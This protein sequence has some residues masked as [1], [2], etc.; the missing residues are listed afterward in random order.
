MAIWEA[1]SNGDE[2]H[3]RL[4]TDYGDPV[5]INEWFYGSAG[6]WY[7]CANTEW[8]CRE[9]LIERLDGLVRKYER[10]IAVEKMRLV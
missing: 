8:Q 3:V 2:A 1:V 9:A 7:Y 10:I 6:V 4:N 5:R